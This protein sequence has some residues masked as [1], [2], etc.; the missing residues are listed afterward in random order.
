MARDRLVFI[1][2]VHIGVNARTNWYQTRY[3]EPMLRAVFDA[4]VAEADQID[5]LVLLGDFI[6]QWTYVPSERPPSFAEIAATNP[7]IFGDQGALARALTALDGRVSYVGGNHDMAVGAAEVAQIRSLQ[8]RTPRLVTDFPYLPALGEGRIACAHGH[9]FS[10]F[11]APDW[12]A[13]PKT[14]IPL[15]HAITRLG[16]LW[17]MQHLASGETVADRPGSGEPSGWPFEK[18]GLTTLLAGLIERQDSLA[19]LLLD[20]LLEATRLPDSTPI[21]MADGTTI[22]AAQAKTAYA[23]LFRRFEN[24]IK[25]PTY[26]PTPELASEAA[27]FALLDVDA[28]NSLGH[29]ARWLGKRHRVVVMGHTHVSEEQAQRPLLLGADSIYANS[30]FGCPAWPDLTRA[31]NPRRPTFAEVQVD[32]ASKNLVVRIRVVELVAGDARVAPEPLH[33]V[34]IGF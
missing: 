13:M 7:A 24:R 20:T 33:T 18:A 1:S 29:F 19:D 11:N 16:A 8:G 27:L 6:D 25:D 12:Q 21:V 15:G 14:G 32:S 30:G 26:V 9:Q 17:S 22:T 10:M 2:D 3:H 4:I 31:Q 23:G 34:S 28:R 5:E